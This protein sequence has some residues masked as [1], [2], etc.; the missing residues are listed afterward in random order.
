MFIGKF[1][2]KGEIV[3]VTHNDRHYFHMYTAEIETGDL[4]SE[5]VDSFKAM[6]IEVCKEMEQA[7]YKHIEYV[8]SEDSFIEHCE[9]NE[10]TFRKDG[11]MENVEGYDTK[12]PICF[13][14]TLEHEVAGT[15]HLHVCDACPAIV[16]EWHNT[17]NTTDFTDRLEHPEKYG[18]L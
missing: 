2:W 18:K 16:V 3:T 4:K 6:Y 17:K 11:T 7:G 9:A 14:G 1:E 8:E 5:D 10:W 12:C 15:T 13:E